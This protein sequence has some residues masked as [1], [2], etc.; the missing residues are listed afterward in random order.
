M[1]LTAALRAYLRTLC[2]FRGHPAVIAAETPSGLSPLTRRGRVSSARLRSRVQPS[3]PPA[4]R[5]LA[6]LAEGLP[7]IAFPT[8]QPLPLLFSVV[9]VTE[10]RA[11][12]G[13]WEGAGVSPG[14]AACSTPPGR[15]G[16]AAGNRVLPQVKNKGK[17]FTDLELAF[18]SPSL[19]K[20]DRH[21]TAQRG[22]QHG[23]CRSVDPA[24]YYLLKCHS[25]AHTYTHLC[26]NVSSTSWAVLQC[27]KG[28]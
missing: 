8:P 17:T 18:I 9:P 23:C 13:V 11:K 3:V 26:V 5:L 7:V 4:L 22:T 28:Q 27:R 19:P 20:I 25:P 1:S 24:S 21:P 12:A 6:S 15:G 16:L 2:I 14:P 10:R